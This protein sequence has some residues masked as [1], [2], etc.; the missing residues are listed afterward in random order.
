MSWRWLQHAFAVEPA[1]PAQPTEPQRLAVDALCR[2]IV[3]RKLTVPAVLFLESSRPLNFVGAQALQF[4][5]PF[6]AMVTD[7]QTH[8]HLA[9]FL[10][11]RGA[12]EYIGRR[13]EELDAT[14]AQGK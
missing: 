11:H 13:L 9:A 5:A 1:G 8:V 10:E 7:S 14:P 3:R 4:F 2:E 12:F 6:L